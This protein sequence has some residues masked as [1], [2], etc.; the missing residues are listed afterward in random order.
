MATNRVRISFKNYKDAEL[1]QK[2]QH[3]VQSLTGNSNFSTPNPSL[4][5]VQ[6]AINKYGDA[7]SKAV[8]G[9]K[10]DTA[11]KNQARADLESLLH[12][13]GLYVQLT[14]KDDPSI[15]LSSG[16][17]ISKTPSPVGIL[18]KPNGFSVSPSASKG[19]IDLSTNAING[20][21]T[22][23]YEYTD[24][25]ISAASIWHVVTNTSTAVTI[26]NLQSGKEYAFRVAGVGS[27]PTRVY[28]DVVTSFVL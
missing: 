10:Q 28:S 20:A 15:I 5:D 16:F 6:T 12:D 21:K 14:G 24:A 19:S 17:D 13:L 1:E 7:L 4:A 25:P 2:A 8:D 27:D 11:V 22:Y 23:Q 3:I 18:P 26:N 9:S